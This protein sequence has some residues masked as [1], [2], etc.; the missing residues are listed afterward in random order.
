MN[1]IDVR[2][3]SR[4]QGA[5]R[6]TDVDLVLPTGYVLGLVGRNGSGKTTTIKSILGMLEPDAGSVRLFDDL[7]PH[8]PGV[9]QRIGVVLDHGFIPPGWRV[10][11][12][13]R[14]LRSFYRGWDD[15]LFRSLLDGFEIPDYVRASTLSRGQ[16]VK[17]SL[18]IALAHHPDLLVLD[19]PSSGL[20]PV[21]RADL[22]DV[23]RRF[24]A[25]EGHSVL[26]STHITTDLDGLADYVVV[27]DRGRTAWS[28]TM[29]EL[30]EEFAVARG[31]GA[32]DPSAESLLVGLRR[33]GDRYDGLI[34]V[35]D[36]AAFGGST[37]LDTA[38]TDDVLVYLARD[39]KSRR[40]QHA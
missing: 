17:L 9:M 40:E 25:E 31:A 19:E 33:E 36:S 8:S 23:L 1:A 24:V 15:G 12:I 18:A 38:S 39:A 5:F 27:L 2:G 35:R 6:L 34:R 4:T 11:R 26:F 13:G 20:D 22:T 30:H 3:L 21:S 16:A 14:E 10:G 37:V 28:G 32:L 7:T 29:L